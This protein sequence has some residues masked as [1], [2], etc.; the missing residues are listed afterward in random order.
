VTVI[1]VYRDFLLYKKGLY[2][3]YPKN[4]KYSSGHAVK[5][6]GWDVKDGKNCWLIENT[7]GPEWGEDGIACVMTNMDELQ[8]ERFTIAPALNNEQIENAVEADI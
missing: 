3:V 8:I 5:L 1:P 7:W 4:H 2:Q 6:I